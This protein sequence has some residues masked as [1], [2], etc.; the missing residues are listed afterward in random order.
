MKNKKVIM[1]LAIIMMVLALTVGCSSDD[2]DDGGD[3]I[4]I[5]AVHPG[6]SQAFFDLYAEIIRNFEDENPGIRIQFDS[7]PEGYDEALVTL[8]AAGDAPDVIRTHSQ[9]LG[10]RVAIGMLSPITTFFNNEDFGGDLIDTAI[11]R[12][13]DEIYFVDPYF[14]VMVLYYN[15]DMFDAA[16]LA[17]PADDWTWIDLHTHAD[18]LNIMDGDVFTQFGYLSDWYNRFWMMYY[19]SHGGS[20]FDSESTPT[21]IAFDNQTA[22]DGIQLIK[23]MTDTVGI[24]AAVGATVSAT[25]NFINNRVAMTIDGSWMINVFAEMEDLNFGVALLPM[26][27]A[28]RGGMSVSAGET[29]SA[30]TNHPEEAWK[31]IMATFSLE[32]SLLLSGFGDQATS[33]GL[34]V[35]YS[36]YTDPRWNPN[37]NIEMAGRQ[38]QET[39]NVVPT[40]Q[41][42]A[43]WMWDIL[44][45]TFQEMLADD[46]DVRATLDLI[47]QRTQHHVLDDM[48]R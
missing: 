33:N 30:T 32:S 15:R 3:Y 44:N 19:W 34:P 17:H 41:F 11:V 29:M 48:D 24:G 4:T 35:W 36:A 39:I 47:I 43:R 6:N 7:F 20:F 18:L 26:G 14:A 10:N 1:V 25:E 38:A 28:G 42:T 16:G 31:Y 22:L 40:F 9:D 12:F 45:P 13:D 21:S 5:R 23:D 46:L 8:F 27:P 2:A 37:E